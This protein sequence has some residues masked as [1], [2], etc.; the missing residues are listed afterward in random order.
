MSSGVLAACVVL[1]LSQK[2][3]FK[4]YTLF[5]AVVVGAAGVIINY[6]ATAQRDLYGAY[7][8]TAL[9]FRLL[10]R[11]G[12]TLWLGVAAVQMA[13]GVG[14]IFLLRLQSSLA[15]LVVAALLAPLWGLVVELPGD[16]RQLLALGCGA[17]LGLHLAG[18]L[19]LRLPWL[20][21]SGRYVYLLLRHMY[22]IYGLQLLLE[23][24]WKRVRLPHVLRLF[25]LSRLAAQALILLY[26]VQAVR[27]E[28][29]APPAAQVSSS[30]TP[31]GVLNKL[32]SGVL[33]NLVSGSRGPC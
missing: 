4:F 30:P 33:S 18:C 14:Y 6:H 28:D 31:S 11:S 8:K 17:L 25:W 15:A 23:D 3:L 10:P 16:G 20:Y 29:A 9:G 12:P 1:L 27:R 5:L 2:A 26:V 24:T 13:L 22:R 21:Y 32:V 7:Y 19:V